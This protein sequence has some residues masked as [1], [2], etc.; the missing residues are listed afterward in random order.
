MTADDKLKAITKLTM[1]D[2]LGYADY[3]DIGF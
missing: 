1:T 3:C 2:G